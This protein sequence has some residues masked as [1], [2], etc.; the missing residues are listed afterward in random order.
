MCLCLSIQETVL[1]LI[2]ANSG[3]NSHDIGQHSNY[4]LFSNIYAF[5]QMILLHN[6]YF[7]DNT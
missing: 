1:L 5:G 7:E 4:L 2:I 3:D 6:D